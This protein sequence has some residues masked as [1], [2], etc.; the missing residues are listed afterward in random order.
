MKII[1]LRS[2][3]STSTEHDTTETASKW[4]TAAPLENYSSLHE[5]SLNQILGGLIKH[6][7]KHFFVQFDFNLHTPL[8]MHPDAYLVFHLHDD[9]VPSKLSEGCFSITQLRRWRVDI[10]R[11]NTFEDFLNSLSKKHFGGFL[12]SKKK[13]ESN[14]ATVEYME[15]WVDHVDEAY[16]LY[17]HIAK[18]HGEQ[19]YDIRY[20]EELAKKNECHL[21]CAWLEGKMIGMTVLFDELPTLHSMCGGLDY[22]CSS[23][24][25]TYSWLHFE[26]IRKAIESKKYTSVDVGLTADEAKASIGFKPA[27]SRMDIYSKGRMTRGILKMAARLFTASITPESKLKFGWRW[28]EGKKETATLKEPSPND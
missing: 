27:L 21:L 10:S 4:V 25:Y 14:G 28:S 18:K 24:C 17:R 15:S 3:M 7:Q 23:K 8:K 12:K 16:A 26:I 6:P 2:K 13:F 19:L 9:D 5:V 11:F 20:F 1:S 22:T